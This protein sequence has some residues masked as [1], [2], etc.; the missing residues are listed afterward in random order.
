M[1]SDF[2]LAQRLEQVAGVPAELFAYQKWLEAQRRPQTSQRDY[3]F[4]ELRPRFE[5]RKED[6]VVVV[7]GLELVERRSEVVLQC[8]SSP[9]RV[10]LSGIA[11]RPAARILDAIDGRRCLLE[12][13]WQSGVEP[14]VFAAFLR[15]TFGTVV[16]APLAIERLESGLSGC[17]LTR[18]P[19]APYAIERAYWHNMLDVRTWLLAHLEAVQDAVQFTDLLRLLHVLAL[20]GRTLSSFYKPASPA[21]DLMVSPGSFY[22]DEPRLM[23]GVGEQLFLDGPRVNVSLLGGAQYHR[24]LY[25]DLGDP[26]ALA[27]ERSLD[28]DGLSWGRVV[29]ARAERDA[30]A[31]PWFCP[32]RP[33]RAE[34]LQALRTDLRE[35][36]QAGSNDDETVVRHAA[37]FHWGFVRLHPFHCANQ[38]LAMNL[39]NACLARKLGAG[40]PH[41]ILDH[42][43]LRLTRPAYEEAFR[44]AV[45]CFVVGEA[46]PSRRLVL[47][48]R[49]NA[50]AFSLIQRLAKVTGDNDADDL[51]REAGDAACW[52][53]LRRGPATV[54]ETT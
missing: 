50:E 44:R 52:A 2:V 25:G 32:P 34:H 53:L 1:N 45:R 21:S 15:A 24:L 29:Q 10:A 35:A 13:R 43:A 42:L 7:P 40:M 54:D 37:R 22:H 49:R 31:S 39:V 27:A 26:D 20:M 14:D 9:V 11:R 23:Q 19:G 48:Q 30:R 28:M 51:V 33:I 12:V 41:L 4:A 5:P 8:P 18:F 3:L 16:L 36:L 6:V 46:D 17:E 47:L 38:S